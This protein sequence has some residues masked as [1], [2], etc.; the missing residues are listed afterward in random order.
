VAAVVTWL[1]D[2]LRL[3]D[4]SALYNAVAT[5]LPVAV[6]YVWSPSDLGGEALGGA[7]K[8]WLE[9]ALADLDFQL[10]KH[11]SQ[12]VVLSGPVE[13]S[14]RGVMDAC[15]AKDIFW[16]RRYFPI[17]AALDANLERKFAADGYGVHASAASLLREPEAVMHGGNPYKVFTPYY[18]AA[19]KLPV[20]QMSPA[21]PDAIKKPAHLPKGVTLDSLE[22]SPKANWVA[23]L[24]KAWVP[25]RAGLNTLLQNLQRIMPDYAE[26][27]DVPFKNATSRL[28]P[29]LRFGQ[30]G[31]SQILEKARAFE[32][33]PGATTFEKELH[34]REF[35]YYMIH[36]FPKLETEPMD[37]SFAHMSWMDDEVRVKAW[38][39]GLTGFP[40][41]DAGMRQLW[42]TGWMHNRVRMIVGSFLVKDIL[43]DWRRGEAWFMNTLVDADPASNS[44]GWQWVGG[45]GADAAPY[46]RVF[47]PVLQG[48]K[49]DPDGFY[50]RRYV[51]E[52]AYLPDKW[53]HTPWTA[54]KSALKDAGITLGV[55]YPAPILDHDDARKRALEAYQDTKATLD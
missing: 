47:N 27:R 16:N 8:W 37:P 24:A 18:N 10:R 25:T 30:I 26:D 3:D 11:G 31:V 17:A 45:C 1:R 33:G 22:L 36:H 9:N 32:P 20:R 15:G 35:A 4:N 7:A 51:P 19:Q 40:I 38:K 39:R 23:T 2:D 43:A 48:R 5:G 46:F 29:Y 28:S 42:Q 41:V 44:F 21:L 49:F 34:W 53:I 52:L 50:V 54:P 12:L 14:L 6:V 55:E 13:E